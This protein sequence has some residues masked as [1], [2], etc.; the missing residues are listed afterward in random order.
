MCATPDAVCCAGTRAASEVTIA[1]ARLLT[2]PLCVTKVVTSLSTNICC[3]FGGS[4]ARQS[5]TLCINF[6]STL[7][8]IP[9]LLFKGA[10]SVATAMLFSVLTSFTR[11]FSVFVPFLSS[12][13]TK[14]GIT[15]TL[16]LLQDCT[17]SILS[18]SIK[19]SKS[20]DTTSATGIGMG[21]SIRGISSSSPN[22]L[23]RSSKQSLPS[24]SLTAPEEESYWSGF[25]LLNTTLG[26]LRDEDADEIFRFF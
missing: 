20:L 13:F 15:P 14:L 25:S 11:L 12:D 18:N 17:V 7:F 24:K 23:V 1:K 8:R 2:S 6:G 26:T 16:T 21:Q 5:C 10:A 19:P 4:T 9:V 3:I 22:I